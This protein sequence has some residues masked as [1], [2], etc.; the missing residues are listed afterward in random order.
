MTNYA[1]ALDIGGTK[2]AGA[3]V[4]RSG[5][6]SFRSELKSIP[7]ER[8][9][10]FGQVVSCIRQVL[11]Q[12]D[13][14]V[15]DIAGMGVGVPGKVDREKGIAV[16]Q[17]NLPWDH[18]PVVRRLREIFSVPVILDNDVCMAAYGEWSM[19]GKSANET[20][21]YLTVSTGIACSII[22]QGSFVRGAG[23]AGELGLLK[24]Q[25]G[26]GLEG[27]LEAIASGPAIERRMQAEQ[28]RQP[29][30]TTRE[31]IRAYRQGHP[32]ATQVVREAVSCLARGL[33]TVISLLDPHRIV[34]GGGVMQNHPELLTDLKREL[35]P[36]LIPE[37]HAALDRIR[38]TTLRGDAG[39]IGA[40][41]RVF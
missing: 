14:Q 30:Y 37:Q 4:D 27:S 39:L 7:Q 9:A 11:A 10:M 25:E 1:L 16:Y 34:L 20:F 40:G 3:L 23:F 21:V 36:L 32:V 26:A 22:H 35:Q 2:I 41:L 5:N 18:F 33:H 12:A 31:V 6:C 38:V 8:E 17:N 13:I 28:D 19:A 15:Q 24:I 29:G